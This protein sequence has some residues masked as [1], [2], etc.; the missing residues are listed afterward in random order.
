[1]RY[2]IVLEPTEA[3][4]AVQVPDLAVMTHGNSI[5]DAKEAAAE[6]IRINLEAYRE[7]GQ[8]VPERPSPLAHL[9]NPDFQDL[10]FTYVDVAD[11]D[12][13]IAA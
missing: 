12:E 8:K 6:A 11:A 3:G 5:P 1:M 4:F 7:A 2:L 10:L 9:E 13:R